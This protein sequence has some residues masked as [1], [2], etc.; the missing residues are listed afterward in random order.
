MAVE[1]IRQ[2]MGVGLLPD[3][4]PIDVENIEDT[5]N[6]WRALQLA[7]YLRVALETLFRVAEVTTHKLATE[8]SFH[9]AGHDRST[10]GIALQIA[11]Q[12]VREM[13]YER[14]V[15]VSALLKDLQPVQE[16]TNTLYEAGLHSELWNPHVLMTKLL[17][18]SAFKLSKGDT[19][20][21]ASYAFIGVLWCIA[22]SLL[23]SRSVREKVATSPSMSRL[24]TLADEY[25][26]RPAEAFFAHI[27]REY[28]L[29]LHASVAR[30]RTRADILGN[31]LIRNRFRIYEGDTG[32]ERSLGRGEKLTTVKLMPDILRNA[33]LLLTQAGL[34]ERA[35]TGRAFRLTNQGRCWVSR[36]WR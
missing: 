21:A 14:D 9:G 2:S 24:G 30:D 31:N 11:Q 34:T 22:E 16:N 26:N 33:L 25:A 12:A 29:K 32:L 7:Q 27:V 6:S 28:V 4:T 17:K 19:G 23:V 15:T 35:P 5:Q 36:A 8:N 3:L 10:T 20:P 1:L 13:P 18:K